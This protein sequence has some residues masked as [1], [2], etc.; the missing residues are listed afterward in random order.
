MITGVVA[1]Q[2]GVLANLSL[3]GD[4]RIRHNDA[5]M[6]ANGDVVSINK[7]EEMTDE[8]ISQV[9]QSVEENVAMNR[10]EA[11]SVHGGLDY[12]RVMALLGD[13]APQA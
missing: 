7:P 10:A 8:E 2:S 6:Q 11:L 9:M 4:K 1:N 13:L 12:G 3:Q 5:A